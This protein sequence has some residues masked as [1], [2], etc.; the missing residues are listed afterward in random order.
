MLAI[1]AAVIGVL[2]E[3]ALFTG[4]DITTGPDVITKEEFDDIQVIGADGAESD[5]GIITKT[6]QSAFDGIMFLLRALGRVI[7]IAPIIINVFGGGA[8]AESVAYIIQVGIWL[9][10][11]TAM[12]QAWTKTSIAGMQ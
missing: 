11:A 6:A 9:T 5:I 12:F 1:F 10:Y 2:D 7:W 8:D 4:A 3:S